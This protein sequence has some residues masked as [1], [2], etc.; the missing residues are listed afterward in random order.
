M[1]RIQYVSNLYLRD[2]V[3]FPHVVRPAARYL[4]LAGNIGDPYSQIHASFMDYCT[5]HWDHVY[6]VPG[7]LE[8]PH[9]P[10][11]EKAYD[12]HPR[13]SLLHYNQMS[14]FIAKK[15]VAVL[16]MP[17]LNNA[18]ERRQFNSLLDYWNYQKVPVCAITHSDPTRRY[19]HLFHP[20]IKAWIY[21]EPNVRISDMYGNM[22]VAANGARPVGIRP[23]CIE[24]R[25][26]DDK[27]DKPLQELSA[28]A[29]L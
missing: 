20:N 11:L 12:Y 24:F 6:Y 18:K 17:F 10:A 22:Y 15:N 9:I 3:A 8:L 26:G 7:I 29:V 4:A 5:R 1:F 14:H 25:G 16:G 23:A 13:I 28:A 19:T 27:E 2:K 21:G